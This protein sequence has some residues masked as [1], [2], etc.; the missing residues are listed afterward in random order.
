MDA[1]VAL[2]ERVKKRALARKAFL[3]F[4]HVLIGRKISTTEGKPVSEGL[5]WRETAALLKK[6][7]WPIADV[8]EL[9]L[10]PEELPPRDRQRF[11]YTAII[12]AGVDSTAAREAGDRFAAT[13]SDLGY[14]VGPPPGG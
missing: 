1:L 9:G 11:W 4:L 6:V 2:L 10:D 5:T 14:E 12:R 3:G 13:L 7:R 8:V